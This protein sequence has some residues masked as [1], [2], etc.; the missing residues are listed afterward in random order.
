MMGLPR[1]VM[2]KAIRL[3]VLKSSSVPTTM[4]KLAG[5]EGENHLNGEGGDDELDGKEG[6][7]YLIGGG[8]RRHA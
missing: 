4:T 3:I 8:G 6:N 5:D 1:A 2:L 7:D